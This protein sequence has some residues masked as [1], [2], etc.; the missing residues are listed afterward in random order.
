MQTS[1]KIAIGVGVLLL[2]AAIVLSS[3]GTAKLALSPSSS[4]TLGVTSTT[5]PTSASDLPILQNS[6]PPFLGIA[7][8]WNTPNNQ[9]L[10]PESL[11]GKVVLVDFW[12]YS[13]INCLRTLPFLKELQANY[14]SKGLVIVGVHTPEFDFE[15]VPANVGNAITNLGITW[16]VALDN[17]YQ[18]WN[19]YQNEYWPAE[20]L[21][22]AQGRLRHTQFGEGDYDVTE[23]AIRLLL[24]D[25]GA[26]GLGSTTAPI[27]T[28]NFSLIET[29]ETY[30]G[31]G[32][33]T[34]FMNAQNPSTN[35]TD[36]VLNAKPTADQ[37]SAGGSWQFATEYAEALS[38][39]STFAFNVQASQLHLVLDSVDGKDK[40]IEV[41]IDGGASQSFTINAPMLY[42]VA[43][44]P[45]GGQHTVTIKMING[46]VRFYSATFS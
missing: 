43:K 10:T 14:A 20:Y 12:T 35:P 8:W 16:P 7:Q 15:G 6:M 36:Y 44:F 21:F 37:W 46:G 1:T 22:D 28:P 23:A 24:A 18:T 30:F 45:N 26:T 3:R 32:R 39:D 29:P 31:L 27:Q 19:A 38:D 40:T 4:P 42:T 13:C 11:K 41:S 34:A 25:N 33:G 9:P 5:S 17:R 2:V